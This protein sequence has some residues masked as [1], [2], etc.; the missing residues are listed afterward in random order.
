MKILLLFFVVFL[1]IQFVVSKKGPKVT[2]KVFF[3]IEIGG[4]NV[5][6]I[7]IGLFGK[8]VPKTVTNFKSLADGFKVIRNFSEFILNIFTG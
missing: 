6:K 8:T 2:D 4:K 1:V 3:E 5:G 7:I